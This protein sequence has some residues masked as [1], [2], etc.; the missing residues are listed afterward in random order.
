ME[1]LTESQIEEI[2]NSNQALTEKVNDL[3]VRV[4]ALE[5]Q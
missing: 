3:I 4:T 1:E 2:K 5:K